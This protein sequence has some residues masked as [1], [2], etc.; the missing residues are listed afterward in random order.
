M[1]STFSNKNTCSSYT[2]SVSNS[3]SLEIYL[4]LCDSSFTPKGIRPLK[5]LGLF[6][7]GF[8]CMV[9]IQI[10]LCMGDLWCLCTFCVCS[11]SQ[12][13]YVSSILCL[14][15]IQFR[16][17]AAPPSTHCCIWHAMQWGRRTPLHTLSSLCVSLRHRRGFNL[18]TFL[19]RSCKV[20]S[21]GKAFTSGGRALPPL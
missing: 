19:F 11:I 1:E 13:F 4:R 8:L 17:T 10:F 3:Y 15:D 5:F 2:R 6:I 14:S 12:K 16:R 7:I 21:R 9:E 18:H 20:G